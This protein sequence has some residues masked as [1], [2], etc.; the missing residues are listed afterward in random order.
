MRTTDDY[1]DEPESLDKIEAAILIAIYIGSGL[2]MAW[3]AW[4]LWSALT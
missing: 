3:I 2:L 4:A 1:G